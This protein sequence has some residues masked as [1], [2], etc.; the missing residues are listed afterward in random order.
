MREFSS[1][2]SAREDL[3]RKAA[4]EKAEAEQVPT[5]VGHGYWKT[6]NRWEKA[7]RRLKTTTAGWR[8][9]PDLA[10]EIRGLDEKEQ[11]FTRRLDKSTACSRRW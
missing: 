9:E 8:G 5:K 1:S 11:Q 4:T 10:D 3:I 7:S 2:T 6:A